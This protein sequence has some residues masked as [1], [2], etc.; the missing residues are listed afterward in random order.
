M[1]CATYTPVQSIAI[2]VGGTPTLASVATVR[3][4]L[5]A[6]LQS[7]RLVGRDIFYALSAEASND[8]RPTNAISNHVLGR[9]RTHGAFRGS[10]QR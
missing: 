6:L 3:P 8:A 9:C 4:A 2:Q 10:G 7:A 1:P 5:C